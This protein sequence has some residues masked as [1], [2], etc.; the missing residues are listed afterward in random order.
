MIALKQR[1][2]APYGNMKNILLKMPTF[3]KHHSHPFISVLSRSMGDT[4]GAPGN[5]SSISSVARSVDSRRVQ[6]KLGNSSA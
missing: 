2:E 4:E 6:K 5:A 3:Y 1:E